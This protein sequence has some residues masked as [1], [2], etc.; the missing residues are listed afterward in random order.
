M[1]TPT[2]TTTEKP[3]V[4]IPGNIRPGAFRRAADAGYEVVVK[5]TAFMDHA[6]P[7]KEP[8]ESQKF[9][10]N[11][12][13]TFVGSLLLAMIIVISNF[14]IES[15]FQRLERAETR[16]ATM[17]AAKQEAMKNFTGRF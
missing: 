6:P 4:E 7:I 15:H 2:S 10:A 5:A 9:R 8:T 13:L 16:H 14:M 12:L 1:E 17:L 11:V 3:I